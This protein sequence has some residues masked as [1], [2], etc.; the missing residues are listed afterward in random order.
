MQDPSD[1]I[2]ATLTPLLGP[3]AAETTLEAIFDALE[4]ANLAIQ[5]LPPVVVTIDRGDAVEVV[6]RFYSIA[7]AESFLATSATIDPDDLHAGLYGIDAPHGV[8]SDSEAIE[9]ARSLGFDVTTAASALRA[10]AS[11]DP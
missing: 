3:A 2:L 1:L 11:V 7:G 6:E 10:L 5:P 8:G 9:A 4:A